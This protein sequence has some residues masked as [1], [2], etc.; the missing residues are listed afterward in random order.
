M[1]LPTPDAL[2]AAAE[3]LPR[4][5]SAPSSEGPVAV[6]VSGGADSVYLLCALWADEALR[7]RLRVL[8]FDHRVRGEASAEDARFVMALSEALGVP[9]AAG[10][11]EGQGVAA[12]AELRA[13]RD[14]FFATQRARLG[15]FLLCTA[16]H[17]DDVVENVLLRLARGAGLA[18]LAAP[19][20]LQP[21]RDGHRRWRP[22]IQAGLDKPAVLAGLRAAGIPWRE[23]AT[24]A[25]PV[26]ARNRVRAWL[27]AG[28]VEALGE[29]YAAGFA[30]SARIAG[31]AQAALAEWATELGCVVDA[32]GRLPVGPLKG[33][34]SALIQECLR[35]FLHLH[36][37]GEP[38]PD[39]LRP[40]AEAIRVGGDAR[41]VVRARLVRVQAG[42]LILADEPLPPL[43]PRERP[44]PLGVSDQECGLRAEVVDVDE[45]TWKALSRG[46]VSPARETYLRAP[47]GPLSWR[48]RKE[49]DRYQP[50][51]APGPGKLSDLLINRKIPAETREALPVVLAGATILWVPGLPPAES[52][53]LT[54]P[55]KGALRLTWDGPCLG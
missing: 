31:E 36:G 30:R 46:D 27:A 48:G 24:N 34:P 19:R 55:A 7:P 39:A 12:E 10:A 43:G 47:A 33:K 51:G 9:C 41:S 16:H 4:L 42:R 3:R 52:A 26:A 2:R 53:R 15:C 6:A 18:G 40:L 25:L 13:A 14:G 45:A 49:G 35:G 22:L 44:L 23:D 17:L 21:F 29:S 38:G 8:H 5:P 1:S 37:V 11:R 28:G 20:V 50:L 54:G 32:V